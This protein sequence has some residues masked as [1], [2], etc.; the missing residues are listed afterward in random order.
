[1]AK[2]AA[3]FLDSLPNLEST[4][5]RKGIEVN[6]STD[7]RSCPT[8]CRASLNASP[9]CQLKTSGPTANRL[10]WSGRCR[11]R[12]SQH[13]LQMMTTLFFILYPVP[14]LVFRTGYFIPSMWITFPRC[15]TDISKANRIPNSTLTLG[16]VYQGSRQI[17]RETRARIISLWNDSGFRNMAQAAVNFYLTRFPQYG[18]WRVQNP[19]VLPRRRRP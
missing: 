4:M 9:R 17:R 16:W 11:L 15:R 19:R 6:V 13:H 18:G 7:R 12:I 10:F 14:A 3:H 2:P 8:K 1:M 5:R